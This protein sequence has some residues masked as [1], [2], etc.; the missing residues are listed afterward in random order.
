MGSKVAIIGLPYDEKSSFLKGPSEAPQKIRGALNS[1]SWTLWTEMGVNLGEES[2]FSDFGD[3]DCASGGD[4]FSHIEEAISR[5]LKSDVRPIVL[6]GDH[7]ITYPVIRAFVKRFDDLNIFQFDA[8][9]DLYEELDGDRCSH[10]CP[11]A[12]IMEERLIARLVQVGVRTMNDHQRSQAEKF[13]V[14]VIEMRQLGEGFT[15]TFDSPLYISFDMDALDPAFAPGVSHYEPG[16]LSTRQVINMIHAL[17]AKVVG[18]DI[19]ELNPRRDPLGITAVAAAKIVKEI[20]G[21][22]IES[23]SF[24]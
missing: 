4:P 11:F 23:L 21:A 22:C 12:R 3:V 16:G 13:G 2:I 6:G 24:T 8:H 15:L 5:I 19:V 20:A 7:S 14:E 18:A 10:A 9:P 17:D 1:P